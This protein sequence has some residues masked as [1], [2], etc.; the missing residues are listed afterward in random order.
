MIHIYNFM[1]KYVCIQYV[2]VLHKYDF[3]LT[4]Q[5]LQTP[6][7]SEKLTENS[8]HCLVPCYGVFRQSTVDPV[9]KKQLTL[10]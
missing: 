4:V 1:W 7:L 2:I 6:F 10:I 9:A 8:L 5:Y 3:V